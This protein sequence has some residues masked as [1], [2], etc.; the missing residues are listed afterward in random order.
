M[1]LAE[2]VAVYCENH[3]E[4]T[5]TPCGQ[6]TEICMLKQVVRIEPLAFEGL[7]LQPV[8]VAAQSKA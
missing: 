3:T 6:N 7:V 4:H 2:T 5:D 8:T 1:L